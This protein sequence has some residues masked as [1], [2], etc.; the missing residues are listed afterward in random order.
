LDEFWSVARHDEA[1]GFDDGRIAALAH[2]SLTQ[3][4]E[5]HHAQ[6]MVESFGFYKDFTS[7]CPSRGYRLVL[8]MLL[9]CRRCAM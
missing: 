9:S 8:A 3:I 7:E 4:R 6:V 2:I 1:P 5:L